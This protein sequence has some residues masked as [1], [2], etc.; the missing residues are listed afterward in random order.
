[1]KVFPL[2]DSELE[3]QSVLESCSSDSY[4]SVTMNG[5]VTEAGTIF[6]SE[7]IPSFDPIT[8]ERLELGD[9]P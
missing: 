6:Y 4:N 9:I 1:M 3:D 5:W 8:G 7:N 2:I